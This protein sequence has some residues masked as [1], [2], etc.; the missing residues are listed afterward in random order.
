MIE[1]IQ[2]AVHADVRQTVNSIR[3]NV[4]V[5]EEPLAVSK[6]QAVRRVVRRAKKAEMKGKSPVERGFVP[7][8]DLRLL[9]EYGAHCPPQHGEAPKETHRQYGQLSPDLSRHVCCIVHV[10]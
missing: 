9:K 8:G 1:S 10:R 2:V 4:S 7:N 3:R 5:E 6:E